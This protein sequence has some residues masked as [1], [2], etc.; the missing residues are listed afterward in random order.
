M[1]VDAAKL[2][3]KELLRRFDEAISEAEATS[4]RV[5]SGY[6]YPS[7]KITPAPYFGKAAEALPT[8]E[9]LRRF[10]EAI[11][12]TGLT[13]TKAH[14]VT[15]TYSPRGVHQT[16][17]PV[18]FPQG[19]HLACPV[20]TQPVVPGSAARD[21][22]LATQLYVPAQTDIL[23]VLALPV[24][25]PG[26]SSVSPVAPSLKDRPP[27]PRLLVPPIS[28]EQGNGKTSP[29]NNAL[30]LSPRPPAPALLEKA[31]IEYE[32]GAKTSVADTVNAGNNN[33]H[34]PRKHDNSNNNK[35]SSASVASAAATKT[36]AQAKASSVL[37]SEAARNPHHD[38]H[39]NSKEAEPAARPSSAE[40]FVSRE[41]ERVVRAEGSDVSDAID[42]ALITM[43]MPS[44][45]N[46]VS[47]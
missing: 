14:M 46:A 42:D 20:V 15:A 12:S 29:R 37:A 1:S 32:N 23:P 13:P 45:S 17:T 27:S 39:H 4:P 6:R 41:S 9:L 22:K 26:R 33:K 30:K 2:D 36:A 38:D 11:N 44:V 47:I 34:S 16:T 25:L 10:D 3:T 7:S 19:V 18:L 21:G 28:K 40:D 24:T 43:E 35:D 31:R 8:D 5:T